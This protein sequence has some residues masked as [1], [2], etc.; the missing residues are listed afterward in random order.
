MYLLHG[1]RQSGKTTIIHAIAQHFR[2]ISERVV[3]KGFPPGLE[4]YAIYIYFNAG[5]DV[6]NRVDIAV[7]RFC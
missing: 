7:A 3:T 6:E 5:I 4:V 2:E 1:H